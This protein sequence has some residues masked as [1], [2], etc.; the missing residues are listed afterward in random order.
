[1][2][3]KLFLIG[4]LAMFLIPIAFAETDNV[5]ILPAPNDTEITLPPV[6]YTPDNPLYGLERFMERV[7][8]WLTFDEESKIK[9]Q[10]EYAEKRLAEAKVM[11]ERNKTD[12][13]EKL[14]K[15]YEYEFNKTVERVKDNY[16]NCVAV[17]M[18][19]CE[20]MGIEEKC[21][22]IGISEEA[23]GNLTNACQTYAET[24]CSKWAN[25]TEMVSNATMKHIHVLQKV[26]EKVP[27]QAKPAIQHAIKSSQKSQKV[28]EVKVREIMEIRD[29]LK[30]KLKMKLETHLNQSL[31]NQTMIQN[32]TQQMSHT[33]NDSGYL[34]PHETP[35][36]IE[37]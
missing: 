26:L 29:E 33:P 25:L 34:P 11:A 24:K 30:E 15:E 23:C 37:K 16:E 35:H 7:R 18:Q 12:Y 31:Q 13:A 14:L 3:N 20:Q 36:G 1:M 6:Q 19:K 10:L 5:T 21:S 32:M 2:N 17:Q 27:E 9:L 8:L 4:M 28:V 22:A